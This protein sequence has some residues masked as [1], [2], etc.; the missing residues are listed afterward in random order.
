MPWAS[1]KRPT[2]VRLAQTLT[3]SRLDLIGSQLAPIRPWIVHPSPFLVALNSLIA[4]VSTSAA[5][6]SWSIA[7]LILAF[8]HRVDFWI[9]RIEVA[10]YFQIQ[11][12]AFLFLGLI[13]FQE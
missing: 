3:G 5:S 10:G 2:A 9:F 4:P 6:V 11:R 8:K 13:A 1:Q 7:F 12:F